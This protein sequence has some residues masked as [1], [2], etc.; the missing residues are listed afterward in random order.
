MT[1]T[2]GRIAAFDRLSGAP[3]WESDMGLGISSSPVLVRGGVMYITSRNGN[4]HLWA[5]SQETGQILWSHE[6]RE[7]LATSPAIAGGHLVVGGDRNGVY[8][9]RQAAG[10][11]PAAPA[12]LQDEA[13]IQA[14]QEVTVAATPIAVEQ[15]PAVKA[16]VATTPAGAVAGDETITTAQP[17]QLPPSAGAATQTPAAGTAVPID[18]PKPTTTPE[19]TLPQVEAAAEAP[20]D[21]PAPALPEAAAAQTEPAPAAP[22]APETAPAPTSTSPPVLAT[23]QITPADGQVPVLLCNDTHIYV[24]G[25]VRA[26]SQI[27]KLTLNEREVDI[28]SGQYLERVDFSGPGEHELV[29]KATGH[30]GN[31]QSHVRRVVALTEGRQSA[32][33]PVTIRLRDGS[34]IFSMVPGLRGERADQMQNTLEIR[35]ASGA[36]VRE[37]VL[38]PGRVEV[39]NWNGTLENGE[40]L[41]PG[42]YTIIHTVYDGQEPISRMAQPL[43]LDS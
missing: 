43:R 12:S 35:D 40:M 11:I 16:P 31:E 4:G 32:A 7:P 25:V 17:A 15:A 23:L 36:L 34:P 39:V 9:F 6:E 21:A 18:F 10:S 38:P 14:P 2:E 24:G 22:A 13:G 20:A 26:E 5:L 37:W 29:V 42:D 30:D 28:S 1:T 3:I 41:P 19:A 27:A 33:R 8:A